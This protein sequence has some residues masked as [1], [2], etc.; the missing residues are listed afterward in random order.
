MSSSK[1]PK[2]LTRL[3]FLFL[4]FIIGLV[5]V[6]DTVLS[7]CFATS[8]PFNEQNPLCRLIISHGGVRQ[9]VIIK[10][11]ATMVGVS[12]LLCL[13][14]TKFRVC[15]TIMFCLS[16]LLFYYLTFQPLGNNWSFVFEEG[17]LDHFFEF[18]YSLD[19]KDTIEKLM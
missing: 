9:L 2:L 12:I 8:L 17:P 15:V 16:L 1:S 10:S 11:V 6:Y 19:K 3:V 4:I 18:Y 5:C 13:A 14:Y 7:I